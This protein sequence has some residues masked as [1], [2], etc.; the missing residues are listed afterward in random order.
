LD[1]NGL[2]LQR[3]EDQVLARSGPPPVGS[4]PPRYGRP[5]APVPRQ[6]WDSGRL[7]ERLRNSV[8]ASGSFSRLGA[9]EALH[10][11][12]EVR[13]A[14]DQAGGDAE[15]DFMWTVQRRG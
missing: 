13:R 5:V 1:L 10:R 6:D 2:T 8:L 12:E 11:L 14:V 7:N 3:A 9:Q 15:I 4:S